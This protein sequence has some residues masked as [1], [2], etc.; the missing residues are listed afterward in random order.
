MV[1]D[2]PFGKAPIKKAILRPPFFNLVMGFKPK[3]KAFGFKPL[4]LSRGFKSHPKP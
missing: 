2:D 3:A 1:G 4:A